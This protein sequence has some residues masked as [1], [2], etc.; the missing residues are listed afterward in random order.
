VC[1]ENALNGA[2]VTA[3]TSGMIPSEVAKKKPDR[4]LGEDRAGKFGDLKMKAFCF[5]K[6][7]GA[8]AFRDQQG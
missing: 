4:A 1:L 3:M 7:F 8:L 2:N 5:Q 6:A